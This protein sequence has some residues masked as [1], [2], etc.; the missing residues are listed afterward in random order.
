MFAKLNYNREIP[1]FS[2]PERT[3]ILAVY[4]KQ[5]ATELIEGNSR[6]RTVGSP[7]KS[8]P[9]PPFTKASYEL[10]LVRKR[11]EFVMT[12]FEEDCNDIFISLEKSAKAGKECHYEATFTIPEHFDIVKTKDILK[13]YFEDLG[14]DVIVERKVEYPSESDKLIIMTLK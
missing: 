3:N 6:L 12:H 4:D 9:M 5:V 1:N 10:T 8:Y 7:V 13:M 2:P 14:Y 11:A